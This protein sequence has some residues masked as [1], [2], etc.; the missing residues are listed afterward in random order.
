MEVK[1]TGKSSRIGKAGWKSLALVLDV[2]RPHVGEAEAVGSRLAVF[3]PKL[4]VF[5]VCE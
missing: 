2:L 3:A 4:R 5:Q 1:T